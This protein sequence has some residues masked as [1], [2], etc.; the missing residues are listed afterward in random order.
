M[1]HSLDSG[2]DLV[3]VII[4]TVTEIPEV[5]IEVNNQ[6]KRKSLIMTKCPNLV[7]WLDWV[8]ILC[9]KGERPY[10]P[11]LAEMQRYCKNNSFSRCPYYLKTENIDKFDSATK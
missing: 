6:Q 9:K 7:E 11:S 8:I 1:F 4:V 3:I 5:L 10:V 2:I